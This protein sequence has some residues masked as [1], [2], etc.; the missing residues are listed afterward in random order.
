MLFY[1]PLVSVRY[2]LNQRKMCIMVRIM[3]LYIESTYTHAP[4]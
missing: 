3:F 4:N 1:C 2:R